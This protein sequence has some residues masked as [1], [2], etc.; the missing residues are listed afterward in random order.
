MKARS[1]MR[2]PGRR[3]D[4]ASGPPN[5][6]GVSGMKCK[7]CKKKITFD[8][9]LAKSEPDHHREKLH[10]IAKCD[11]G[12]YVIP[13]DLVET[14]EFKGL[15]SSD[16][17][18]HWKLCGE[19]QWDGEHLSREAKKIYREQGEEAYEKWKKEVFFPL[20]DARIKKLKANRFRKSA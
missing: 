14:T 16:Q 6:K 9:Y 7:V 3:S 10:V 12:S 20:M 8:H 5:R 13:L 15:V 11:C 18:E 2:S 19:T 4:S 1:D 17:T